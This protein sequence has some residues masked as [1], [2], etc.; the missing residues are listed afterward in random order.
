MNWDLGNNE[1]TDV[2]SYIPLMG[3]KEYTYYSIEDQFYDISSI[4]S[5]G[6]ILNIKI[7]L[8]SKYSVIQRNVFS[9]LD[10]IGQIQK[11]ITKFIMN[12][13]KKNYIRLTI[14][15]LVFLFS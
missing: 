8:D 7:T 13:I 14:M 12:L 15:H 1:V 10:L 6:E 11:S 9:F 3:S 4:E 2:S 5:T